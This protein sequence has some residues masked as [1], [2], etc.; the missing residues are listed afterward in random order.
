MKTLKLT[1]AI[2]SSL[3]VASVLVL[4][5]IGVSASWRQD[6]VDGGIQKAIHGQLV[7]D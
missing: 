7:G 6:N 3:I 4:S 5:P 2:A 1:K